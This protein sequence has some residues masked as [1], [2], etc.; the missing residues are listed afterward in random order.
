MSRTYTFTATTYGGRTANHSMYM[1]TMQAWSGGKRVGCWRT[2]STDYYGAVSFIFNSGD[3]ATVRGCT[4]ESIKLSLSCSSTFAYSEEL[5]YE[6]KV[7]DTVTDWTIPNYAHE[8]TVPRYGTVPIID[9]TVLGVP[10]YGY[11][12]GGYYRT[13]AYCDVTGG[14]LTVVTAET[15]KTITYNGNG[16]TSPS[17]TVVWG[18]GS[19]E[20]VVTTTIPTRTGYSFNGWNT[21]ANGGGTSYQPADDI[22]LTSDIILYAQ[23]TAL[24]SVLTGATN[25]NITEATTVSWT[26]YGSFTNKLRFIFGSVDSGEISVSGSSY[27]YTIPASWYNQIPNSTSGTATVYLY[28][29]VDGILIG[30]SS[31]TFT[32]SVKSSVVPAIGSIS[33]TGVDLMW[34]LYLQGHSSVT[35]SVSNCSAGSGATIASYSIQGHG[36]NYSENR[37]QTSASATSAVFTVSGSQTYT[38]KITDSRGRTASRS[39]TITVT[40]YAAPAISSVTGIRCDSDGTANPTTGTSLKASATF[41]YSAV[42]SNTLSSSLSYKK[43]TDQAYTQVQT[44]ITSGT[45]YIFAVGLA[46]ISSSYDVQVEVT[47]TIG[48]TATYTIIVPPV[49]GISFG[50]KN[51]RARFGGPVE[52]AGLQVDWNADF[53]GNINIDGNMTGGGVVKTVNSTAPD[54]N[55]NVNVSGGGGSVESVNNELPDQNG[56]VTLTANDV[57]ALP[58]SYQP[59]VTSVNNKT[60]TVVIDND[61][62]NAER[63]VKVTATPTAAGWYRVASFDVPSNVQN[64]AWG[65][66]LDINITRTF[67][68]TNNE[69]HYIRLFGAYNNLQ[70]LNEVSQSNSLGITKIRYT[71]SSAKAYI[72]IYSTVITNG[73]AV[74]VDIVPHTNPT[75]IKSLKAETLQSVAD[76]PSGETII[77]EY[78]FVENTDIPKTTFTPFVGTSYNP[79]GDCWYMKAGKNCH[80][81]LGISGLTV[82]TVAT[83]FNMPTDFIPQDTV[84]GVGLGLANDP[85]ISTS[86]ALI[87]NNGVVEVLSTG[88]YAL[89]DIDY[90]L[91]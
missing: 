62:V 55:G 17:S 29:Y 5:I 59:P 50:L 79:Y 77:T 42:G 8:V 51:D 65:F 20:G 52:K 31:Q 3:L 48:N 16:G 53:K 60:G 74:T 7:T 73:N 72:D 35:I 83:V 80:L 4:I 22:T 76:A 34:G 47:D 43:H 56:N 85:S 12:V 81:H 75:Y 87:Y 14:T 69:L 18:E 88:T 54:A 24:K 78:T 64:G 86:R 89:I 61:D 30:T 32:A 6:Q 66:I 41:T 23:W 28:T 1:N 36:L 25:A 39:V 67:G 27:S 33:A 38:A 91:V 21:Q 58:D 37:T 46:E 9:V 63:C 84:C 90:I 57:G 49:V 68:F 44:G 82:G 71:T 45:T 40:A 19:W 26:N 13:Y 10:D 70:F 15:S 2:G 11:V